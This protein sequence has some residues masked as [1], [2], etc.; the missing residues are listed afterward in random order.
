MTRTPNVHLIVELTALEGKAAELGQHI[1]A[2]ARASRGE[3]GV[4]RYDV[5]QSAADENVF[6][7][8][9][10]WRDEAALTAHQATAHV[11]T[12]GQNALPLLARPYTIM[13]G[14]LLDE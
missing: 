3:D 5:V 10:C 12:F 8:I 4:I 1:A 13:A 11:V 2:L 9:E 14:K 7:F 6:R